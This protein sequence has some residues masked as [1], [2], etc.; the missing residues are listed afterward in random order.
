MPRPRKLYDREKMLLALTEA[1]EKGGC[2]AH[3]CVYDKASELYNNGLH[4]PYE[5][6]TGQ[7]I[8]GVFEKG[9]LPYEMRT[10]KGKK[11]PRKG[12]TEVR[13]EGREPRPRRRNYDD[14]RTEAQR[15]SFRK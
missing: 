4:P 5:P 8:R 2:A 12:S 7:F 1:D 15:A 3:S 6:C 10:P 11:V 14:G 13:A 9:E